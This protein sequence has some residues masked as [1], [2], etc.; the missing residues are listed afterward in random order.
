MKIKKILDDIERELG[1]V[2]QIIAVH[3]ENKPYIV[4]ET[5]EPQEFNSIEDIE[6]VYPK[7][8]YQVVV[9]EVK[10]RDSERIN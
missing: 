7:D 3:Y 6:K 5:G 1:Q 8:T 10:Y 4:R 9:L 2:H